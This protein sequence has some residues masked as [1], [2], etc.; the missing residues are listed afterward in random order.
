M[1]HRGATEVLSEEVVLFSRV[2]VGMGSSEMGLGDG[3]TENVIVEKNQ[4]E[5][6]DF[7]IQYLGKT[8]SGRR[9]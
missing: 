5:L 9:K 8:I 4:K 1:K 2:G 6:K 3:L 7:I